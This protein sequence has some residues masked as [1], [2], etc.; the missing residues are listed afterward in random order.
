M[1]IECK[2]QGILQL[3]EGHFSIMK[4]SVETWDKVQRKGGK[5][6]LIVFIFPAGK[7]TWQFPEEVERDKIFGNINKALKPVSVD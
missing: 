4:D 1:I 6:F 7:L 3:P 2:S 5:A